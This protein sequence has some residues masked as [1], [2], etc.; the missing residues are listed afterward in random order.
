[1]VIFGGAKGGGGLVS[2]D[3]YMLDARNGEDLAHW[4][5]IPVIGKTPGRR[6]GH[7]MVYIKP[8]IVVFGGNTGSGPVN[9]LWTLD[10]EVT[11]F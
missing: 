8:H 9:D 1:M 10:T 5:T 3:L 4:M 2:D 11:P 6:Y 7:T